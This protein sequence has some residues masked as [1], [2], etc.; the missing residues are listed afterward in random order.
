MFRGLDSAHPRCN[1]VDGKT[2]RFE[3]CVSWAKTPYPQVNHVLLFVLVR[4]YVD[5]NVHAID[6]GGSSNHI[7]DSARL[8]ASLRSDQNVEN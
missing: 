8:A 5:G 7:D 6:V 4:G 2:P 3:P 1:A